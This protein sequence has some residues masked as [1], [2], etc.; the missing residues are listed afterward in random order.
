MDARPEGKTRKDVLAD[1]HHHSMQHR[2]GRPARPGVIVTAMC[3]TTR[4]VRA[5]TAASGL[6]CC[7]LCHLQMVAAGRHCHTGGAA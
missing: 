7:P 5:V 4:T 3:G 2:L 1:V 6:P